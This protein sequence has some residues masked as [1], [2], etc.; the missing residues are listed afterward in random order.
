MEMEEEGEKFGYARCSTLAQDAGYE[1]KVLME[2]GVPREN[3]YIEYISGGK[4][5]DQRVEYD[6]LMNILEQNPKS[7][8]YATDLTRIARNN[9]DI[10]DLISF[11]QEH[12]LKLVVGD[13]VVSCK[14]KEL[15][16]ISEVIIM[17]LGVFA[18]FDLKLKHQHIKWGIAQRKEKGL[19]MGR[20]VKTKEMLEDDPK[21]LK[22][23]L[24]WKQHLIN[25]SEMQRLLGVNSRTTVYNW[26]RIY[27]G[28][29]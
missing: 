8:L 6:K 29:N 23:Y 2:K 15:D 12:H 20:P 22:Y 26:I 27:E 13:F 5:R 18:T 25:L 19:P 11:V 17:V 14:E 7:D 4:T 3:I 28:K 24:Q 10:I 21:F 9:Q 1:I 16:P